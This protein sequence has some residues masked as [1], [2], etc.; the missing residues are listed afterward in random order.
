M[1]G[2]L[3]VCTGNICRS[4]TAEGVFRVLAAE[5]GL[6]ALVG[7][8]SAGTHDYHVGEPPDP[9]SQAV[10]ARHG[11][12]ISGQR[13]RLLA[14]SDFSRHELLVAMDRGH[15]AV[16]RRR[17]PPDR[18]DRI[19]LFMDYLPG[20]G[21]RDVPDPYYGKAADFERAFDLIARGARAIVEEVR[22]RL[23]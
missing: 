8:G 16:L 13:A 15:E 1:F 23:G 21:L 20:E 4:P 7:T 17:C 11:I 10:A 18:A 6:G 14:A 3:F 5:S 12:D 2:V 19:R 9:R 22:L